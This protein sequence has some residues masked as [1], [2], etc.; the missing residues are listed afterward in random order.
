MLQRGS[1]SWCVP[2]TVLALLK[3][4]CVYFQENE[5]EPKSG[6]EREKK[7]YVPL[8]RLILIGARKITNQK[9]VDHAA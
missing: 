5:L 2:R 4:L 1:P 3:Q 7:D 9:F 8:E 6:E